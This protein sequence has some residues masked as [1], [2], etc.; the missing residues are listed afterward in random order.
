MPV[1]RRSS[2][3]FAVARDLASKERLPVMGIAATKDQLPDGWGKLPYRTRK[4]SVA[5]LDGPAVRIY[6]WPSLDDLA[7]MA[8]ASAGF[9]IVLEWEAGELAGWARHN[10]ALNFDTR[11]E[12]V[13]ARSGGAMELYE[14]I[15]WSG[16]NGWRDDWGKRDAVSDM[17]KLRDMDE[18]DALDLAGY[19]IGRRG[20][21]AIRQLLHLARGV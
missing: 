16:N 6:F 3:V 5:A 11:E 14:R 15:A 18:F 9:V 21:R 8:P 7:S 17:R 13:P 10:Q 4:S 20:N 12:L 1:D 2:Q 19:M